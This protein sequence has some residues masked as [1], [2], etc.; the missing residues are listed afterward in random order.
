MGMSHARI[1]DLWPSLRAFSDDAGTSYGTAKAMK[2]RGQIPPQYWQ[3]LIDGAAARDIADITYERLAAL[4]TDNRVTRA[5]AASA[6]V[7]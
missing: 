2:R 1:F 5:P 6:E 3:R 4:Y 7:A